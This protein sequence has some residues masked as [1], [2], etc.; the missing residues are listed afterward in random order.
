M[1]ILAL[2][3][4]VPGVEAAQFTLELVK[5]E[6]RRAWELHLQ[7]VIRALYFREERTMAVLELEC[8]DADAARA[9]LATLPLVAE[10]LIT[11]EVIAL[12]TYPGFERLF[13]A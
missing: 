5:A 10:G 11:F 8:E 12:R 13:E 4:E 6:A 2:E 1:K 3:Q 7:G 9:V